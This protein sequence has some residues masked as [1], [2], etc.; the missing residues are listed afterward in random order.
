MGRACYMCVLYKRQHAR[1]THAHMP[2]PAVMPP[3]F[4]RLPAGRRR[5]A[6]QR[7]VLFHVL[8]TSYE[9][10]NLEAAE[11]GRLEWGGLVIDEGHRLRN[12][13]VGPG[14]RVGGW[15]CMHQCSS[16]V[17]LSADLS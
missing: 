17:F 13:E 5:E 1:C 3:C 8:L 12:K 14:G 15:V 11:L 6:L 4:P 9:M 16:A 2:M 7:A 10:L